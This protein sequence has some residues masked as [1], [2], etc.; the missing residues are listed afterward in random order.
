MDNEA[1]TTREAIERCT[2]FGAANYAP[3]PVVLSH[4]DGCW[5]TDIEGRRY[6]DM[7]ASYSALNQGHRHPRIMKA[8]EDQ[9]ARLT[10]TS[11]AFHNDAMG[12][13][14]EQLCTLTGMEKAL[15]MNTG[16]EGVETAIKMARRWGYE[17]KGIPDDRASIIVAANNFHGRTTTIVSFSTEEAYRRGFGPFTPGFTVVPFGDAEAV[18]NAV[19]GTTC[20]V[21]VEPI[22]GEGGILI[23]PP[24]TLTAIREICSREKVLFI[25]DEIQ[26]GLGR[27]GK[28]FAWQHEP[29]A[30]PD[31]MILGKAL[32]GGVLP[33][34]AVVASAEAMEVFDPG[35]HG[36]TFGGNPL[37][38]A[39]A[40][41]ALDVIVEEDLSARSADLGA[42]FMEALGRIDS[43]L[44]AEVRGR[45]LLIGVE[46]IPEAGG[47][48]RFCEALLQEGLLCKETHDN[49]IR[50]A[51]PL[52]I[53]W[54]EIEWALERVEKVLTGS[55][56]TAE[57]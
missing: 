10:L 26:T 33:I 46:L 50:F 1:G 23:P 36:S 13:F 40:Q 12:P 4:G 24:G 38:C 35:S 30:R 47:A 53:E 56:S 9:A 28:L 19:D 17:G 43:P 20:A 39:V 44:V 45:G 31:A 3:L 42:R 16:A 48:R 57:A 34:S 21:M 25:L 22:Q 49:V 5:C 55:L 8:L 54:G 18:A 32:G 6:L 11:R 2:R 41:A 15:P 14:L 51:P 37:A 52:T 27:T 7:L 29:E